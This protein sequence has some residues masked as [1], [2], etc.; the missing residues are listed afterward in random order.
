MGR[1]EGGGIPRTT[2]SRARGAHG[3]GHRGRSAAAAGGVRGGLSVQM[4]LRFSVAIAW[5]LVWCCVSQ[6]LGGDDTAPALGRS[7]S[8]LSA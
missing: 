8:R 4:L 2:H 5:R 7:T 3:H 1:L 6:W